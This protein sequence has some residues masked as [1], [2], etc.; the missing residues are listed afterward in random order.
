[1]PNFFKQEKQFSNE[2]HFAAIIFDKV[3]PT[4]D[5]DA[6][7]FEKVACVAIELQDILA[8]HPTLDKQKL[9]EELERLGK[10][11]KE[12]SSSLTPG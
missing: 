2:K 8:Q 6:N 11:K 5:S 1:M 9:I 12:S 3:L 4:L 7:P 10:E